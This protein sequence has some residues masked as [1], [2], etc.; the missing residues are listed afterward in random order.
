MRPFLRSSVGVLVL[1]VG[2]DSSGPSTSDSLPSAR[3]EGSTVVTSLSEGRLRELSDIQAKL[4]EVKSLDA[5]GFVAKYGV[6]FTTAPLPYDPLGAKGLDLI[7][8]SPLA[9]DT[10]ETS[11]L[12]SAGFVVTAKKQYPSF[13]YGYESIY[14]SDLPV[15]VSAD[16]ILQ[17]IH[18]SFDSILKALETKSFS[19]K[20]LT[21]LR[22]MHAAL[23][24]GAGS[25]LPLAAR[26]DVDL[27]LSVALRLLGGSG[28]LVLGGNQSEVDSIV[29]RAVLAEGHK[30][31]NLFGA[32]RDYDFSQF[33]PRG[34]YADDEALSRYFRTMIWLGRTDLR[35][36]EVLPDLSQIFRRRSVESAF[37]LR[38]LFDAPTRA[39]Y[40]SLDKAIGAFVGEHDDMTLGQLDSLLVDLKIPTAGDLATLSDAT[41]AQT[42]VSGGYGAQRI[43]SQL[44][45]N[46]LGTGTSP[47]SSVFSILGQRY[48]LDSHV[49]SNVVRDRIAGWRMM[50]N[51]LDVG[52]AAMNNNQAGVL[53]E[54]ELARYR[55]APNLASM[56]ILADSHPTDYWTANLYNEWL[57]MIRT[58][59]PTKDVANPASV[60]MPHVT[61][62]EAWGRRVLSAQLASW[63]ELRHDTVLYTK[64]SYSGRGACEYPDAYVE[65]YPELFAK[66]GSFAARGNELVGPLATEAGLPNVT[67]YFTRLQ[68]TAAILE[69]M[70][71]NQRTGAP[72]AAEQL[73]FMNKMTF[74]HGC[75][76]MSSFNG[77][78]AKLFYEPEDALRDAP[79]IADVHTQPEDE[80]GMEVGRVLHVATAGPRLMVVTVESCQGPHAYVGLA[81]RY[82]ELVTENFERLTDQQWIQR[83]YTTTPP[84][85]T[86]WLAPLIVK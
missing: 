40:D 80:T 58:L 37:V 72:H 27:Y 83:V 8:A 2:C 39:A 63:A 28:T 85:E 3:S 38:A 67:A 62:T 51:P 7:Q 82:H 6:P 54:P 21:I 15:Y 22:S 47:F 45:V 17:A 41:I 68:S 78:Y 53:L 66:V 26:Q 9:L 65:P 81:S 77:W 35:L 19:V 12:G 55:Y 57:G 36:I 34:H 5:A 32:K 25:D 49:F 84:P 42:I 43:A 50:P 33:A 13:L 61:G 56:R 69:A 71:K 64:Q 10:A 23:E 18:A 70:A 86:P 59:S 44:M 75:E 46:G 11:A 76:G 52:F 48:V 4:D 1:A 79:T 30:E 29:E 74:E 60:G 20:L 73:A 24:A 31:V 16:S 14:V